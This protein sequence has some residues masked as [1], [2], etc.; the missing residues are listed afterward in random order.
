MPE[1]AEH[2]DGQPPSV[3]I[4]EEPED[5]KKFEQPDILEL[6]GTIDYDENYD[7][8]EERRRS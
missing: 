6:F 1:T 2:A 3:A 7:Y 5:E 4:E 8:K